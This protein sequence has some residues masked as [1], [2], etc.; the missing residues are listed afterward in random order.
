[1]SLLEAV[2]LLQA[3]ADLFFLVLIADI[4][5]VAQLSEII[6]FIIFLKNGLL[7]LNTLVFVFLLEFVQFFQIDLCL[8]DLATVVFYLELEQLDA[9][10]L[11]LKI[12]FKI[13]IGISESDNLF[14]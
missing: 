2:N 14:L 9:L 5:L 10:I 1:M 3:F 7:I 4:K 12:L 13:E 11:L 8:G 6:I